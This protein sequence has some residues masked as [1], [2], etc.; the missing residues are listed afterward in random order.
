LTLKRFALAI[1]AL[2]AVGLTVQSQARPWRPGLLPTKAFGCATCHVSAS[3]AG[4]RNPFGEAVKKRLED[5]YGSATARQEPF[6]DEVLAALDSDGDGFSNGVELGD[7]NGDGKTIDLT[8]TRP[9][10]AASKPA[11]PTPVRVLATST[12]PTNGLALAWDGGQG[13][14]LVEKKSSLAGGPWHPAGATTNRQASATGDA[15]ASFYR[16]TDLAQIP[17]VALSAYLTGAAERPDPVVTAGTG[18][19]LFVLEQYTLRFE[20]HYRNLSGAAV[21]AHIHGPGDVSDSVAPLLDLEP[22]RVGA[23]DTNGVFRGSVDLTSGQRAALLGGKTYVNVHTAAHGAGEIRGQVVPVHMEAALTGDASRPTS[24]ATAGRGTGLFALVGN[25]LSFHIEFD[26][27]SGPGVAAH[28]HGP[29]GTD[30]QASVLVDLVPF[31]EGAITTSGIMEGSTNLTSAQLQAVL[32]GKSY[33]NVHTDAH[34]GGEI[35]GQVVSQISALPFSIYPTGAAEV[36]DPTPS[37]ASGFGQF[38]LGG[39]ALRFEVHYRGLSGP[40]AGVHI[41]APADATTNATVAIDLAP[42]LQGGGGAS[43]VLAGS[44][45]VTDP[46]VQ[47][48]IRAGR[49]YF[50]IHTEKYPKGEIRSQIAPVVY[51]AFLNGAAE[52]PT[53]V[54]T[55]A[56]AL[57]VF[58]LIADQLSFSVLYQG[59]SGAA[60]ASHIHG[61]ASA[62]ETAAPLLDMAGFNGGAF[63]ASGLL[64]GATGV[65]PSVIQA[66]VA[67]R[68]YFN[69]HT[70]TNGAGEVRGQ[71]VKP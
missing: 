30:D 42:Y 15:A 33:V 22:Y 70:P 32:T 17:T 25:R 20:V 49:S 46:A 5:R 65:E 27:L 4:P 36:P 11:A 6:W 7:P 13:P 12:A 64:T 55:G 50:N 2:C 18:D 8:P 23:L 37:T 41:H 1:L 51:T 31:A 56:S 43:G 48:A 39:D 53:P 29:G 24:V 57:G 3:G 47:A 62:E 44:V 34:P 71:I 28:I 54:T 68:A 59:L 19:A 66:L 40:V 63:G 67:N 60:V 58:S 14:F 21:A 10:D 16:V 61:P 45:T 26:G 9:G 69:L 52:R 35:R 38:S